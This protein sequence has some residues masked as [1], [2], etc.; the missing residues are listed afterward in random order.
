MIETERLICIPLALSSQCLC[1][2]QGMRWEGLFRE[3]ESFVN[4]ADGNPIYE[5]IM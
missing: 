2:K 3:F 5:N 1:E 4:D